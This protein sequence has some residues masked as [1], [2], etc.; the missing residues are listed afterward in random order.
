MLFMIFGC[1]GEYVNI[2]LPN[3]GLPPLHSIGFVFEKSRRRAEDFSIC[4]D[5]CS[6]KGSLLSY[7]IAFQEIG[8]F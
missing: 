8:K 6:A 7:L 4:K 1:Q 2:L 5:D 3:I